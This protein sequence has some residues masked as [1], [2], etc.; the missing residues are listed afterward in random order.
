M[1]FAYNYISHMDKLQRLLLEPYL[2]SGKIIQNIIPTDRGKIV[3]YCDFETEEVVAYMLAEPPEIIFYEKSD[4]D[5]SK[6]DQSFYPV[7]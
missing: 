5:K 2:K 7:I 1:N 6:D 3:E 4:K